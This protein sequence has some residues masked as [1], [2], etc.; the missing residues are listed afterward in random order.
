MALFLESSMF[1]LGFG[2][3]GFVLQLTGTS[4]GKFLG[5]APRHLA[6]RY[7]RSGAPAG[8]RLLHGLR[9]CNRSALQNTVAAGN[10]L[11]KKLAVRFRCRARIREHCSSCSAHSRSITTP[12]A[13]FQPL[14]SPKPIIL[15][16]SII[17]LRSPLITQSLCS[18]KTE[19]LAARRAGSLSSSQL[20]VRHL[21]CNWSP[22]HV[23]LSTSRRSPYYSK[24]AP[25]IDLL[26]SL[27]TQPSG[28][29]HLDSPFAEP[30]IGRVS[31]PRHAPPVV[32][33][34][35]IELLDTYRQAGSD[36]V[37]RVL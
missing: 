28:S 31:R 17:A 19:K 23:R 34:R 35:D 11:W 27:P 29:T 30:R 24:T 26:S 5:P 9:R 20:V 22:A 21:P 37:S 7:G 32:E 1:E 12:E 16:A 15:V 4:A 10:W 2:R 18:A 36:T 14:I 13:F 25:N 3:S 6:G 33:P 8:S